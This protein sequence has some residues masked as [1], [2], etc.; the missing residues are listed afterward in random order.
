MG[1]AIVVENRSVGTEGTKEVRRYL[2]HERDGRMDLRKKGEQKVQM[3][4]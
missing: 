4:E 1:L 2:S 3:A